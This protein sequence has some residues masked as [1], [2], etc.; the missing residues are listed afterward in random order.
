M[1][2]VFLLLLLLS[3]SLAG[4]VSSTAQEKWRFRMMEY[5]CENLFDTLHDYGKDDTAFTPTGE[6]AWNS[7]RYWKKL[8]QL[9]RVVL[10]AG[11][12]QPIDV[13]GLCEVENDSVLTDLTRR[14]RLAALGYEYVATHSADLRGI[15]VAL[16]YQPATFRLLT[17]DTRS[18]G[19]DAEHERPTRDVLHCAGVIPVGDT[20]DVVVVH[21][22]S[23]RGGV[24]ATEAYRLRAAEVVSAV[25][26][27]LKQVRQQPA[28]VVMGDCN[29][30]PSNRSLQ[31]ISRAGLRNLSAHATAIGSE[32]SE[33]RLK[34]IRGT[35]FYQREWSRID[36]IMLSEA[37]TERYG[38]T[39][40]SIFAPDYLLETDADGYV[41]PFR[42]YRGPIY[43][44]GVSDHL[45]LLLDLWY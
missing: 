31:R 43:H 13:V 33:K 8:G 23:R 20:I 18:I 15:D 19:Y 17:T 9:A 14:T 37:A 24:R 36:N 22:P 16:L 45:P 6:Y 12:L 30:E 34:Q 42:L 32:G 44:G 4:A 2:R 27:S 5:N 3:A 1:N 21:F 39:S 35:Y 10:E 38:A 41:M 26:D 25:V 40:C 11:G 29:D 7:G 28:V